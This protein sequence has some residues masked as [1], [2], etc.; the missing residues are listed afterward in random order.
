MPVPPPSRAPQ[1][2]Q[3]VPAVPVPPQSVE[4]KGKP[5]LTLRPAARVTGHVLSELAPCETVPAPAYEPWGWKAV[6]KPYLGA[7]AG[8]HFVR[9][10]PHGLEIAKQRSLGLSDVQTCA[11][12]CRLAAA[13]VLRGHPG[14]LS[15]ADKFKLHD[16]ALTFA[17]ALAKVF[18]AEHPDC[19]Q[20]SVA[21]FIAFLKPL[22]AVCGAPVETV[23][24]E[25]TKLSKR[26]PDDARP[27]LLQE[28][29]AALGRVRASAVSELQTVL[30]ISLAASA[31]GTVPRK[32]LREPSRFTVDEL[33]VLM[34]QLI[35]TPGAEDALAF[36]RML[37]S[38][39]A[40]EDLS[41]AMLDHLTWLMDAFTESKS[42][43]GREAAAL[44]PCIAGLILCVSPRAL[45]Q[46]MPTIEDVEWLVRQAFMLL[47][48]LSRIAGVEGCEEFGVSSALRRFDRLSQD[49]Q[50]RA[51]EL[52]ESGFRY[53]DETEQGVSVAHRLLAPIPMLSRN[54]ARVHALVRVEA[55]LRRAFADD[56]VNFEGEPM[57][58]LLARFVPPARAAVQ[59]Q[60][61]ESL[62]APPTQEPPPAGAAR[63]AA[64]ALVVVHLP[65]GP[66]ASSA[67]PEP[68]CLDAMRQKWQELAKEKARKK[69]VAFEAAR[70]QGKQAQPL[71]AESDQRAAVPGAKERAARLSR[72]QQG[73][74]L[75]HAA[76]E[77]FHK[78]ELKALPKSVSKSRT[79]AML[80]RQGKFFYSDEV[81]HRFTPPKERAGGEVKDV[82]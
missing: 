73:S 30:E 46:L 31:A 56:N 7:S 34:T 67:D 43:T 23:Q 63:P 8:Q 37:S 54:A 16:D 44:H 32:L 10:T 29:K 81:R 80:Q 2:V 35:L 75:D 48:R 24:E 41:W 4:A 47:G 1:R 3:S 70:A 22:I 72:K 14:P 45:D 52:A 5:A 58:E 66:P 55:E 25:M 33:E 26:V 76:C 79:T 51:R 11:E 61:P 42:S 15:L 65:E 18:V 64:A 71:P 27:G 40:D 39:A 12:F 68:F 53:L 50:V 74:R 13:E 19:D 62:P 60:R 6:V 38:L 20:V 57:D 77:H 36:A 28:I 59:S 78:K 21:N 49:V 69:R 17:H 82:D 9:F